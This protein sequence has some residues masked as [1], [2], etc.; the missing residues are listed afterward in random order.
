MK[1][2]PKLSSEERRAAI[3]RAVRRAFA[4]KGFH[5]TT[6]REL[7]EAAGVS[8]A[9]LFKHFPNKEALYSAMQL[10]CCSERDPEKMERIKN[11]EPSTSTLVLIVHSMVTH[12]VG[13][14]PDGHEDAIIQHRL[15]LRSLMEDGEFA[16]LFFKR[17]LP[18]WISKVEDCLQASIAAGEAYGGPVLSNVSATFARHLSKM[19][20]MALLPEPPIMDYGVPRDNLIEQAV[21]FTLRGMGVKEEAIK[22]YYNP[23]ALAVL[24]G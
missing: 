19:I 22:R 18:G 13:S 5:G 1:T 2:A 4:E 17:T 23:Q 3:I 8:E 15:M 7:A 16:R 24:T 9:L 21:W 6:T 14:R 20:L 12:T 11:L 10:H